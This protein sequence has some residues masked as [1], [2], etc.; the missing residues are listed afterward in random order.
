MEAWEYLS[1][2]DD[3]RL[4]ELGREGW[5]LVGVMPSGTGTATFYFKRPALNFRER[6]TEDQKR[7][8]YAHLGITP[9]GKTGDA[10]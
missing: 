7:H 6:V 9:G 1:T 3:S 10:R 5:E 2:P 4:A 8:H